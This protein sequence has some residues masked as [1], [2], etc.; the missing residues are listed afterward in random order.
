[1]VNNTIYKCD[2]CN[3]LLRFRYRVGYFNIP[4]NIYCPKCNS[5]ISGTI[6]VGNNIAEI[7]EYVVGATRDKSDDYDSVVEL[8]TEFIVDK[9]KKKEDYPEYP[10]SMFLKS[11]L[12]NEKKTKEENC[13]YVLL[14]HPTIILI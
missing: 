12:F 11:N 10:M 5:H 9:S 3:S 2:Y 7:K 13:F 4:I 8:S 1:M 6:V 14:S